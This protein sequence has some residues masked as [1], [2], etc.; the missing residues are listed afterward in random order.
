MMHMLLPSLF[1]ACPAGS[2]R[3]ALGGSRV[4]FINNERVI[5]PNTV[6]HHGDM[7][8]FNGQGDG[9][10]MCCVPDE[11]DNCTHRHRKTNTHTHTHP[12]R[13]A[14]EYRCLIYSF[15]SN[16]DT[17]FEEDAAARWS[18]CEIHIFDCTATVA[19]KQLISDR[20]HT[21]ALCLDVVDEPLL[22]RM[23]FSS[24]L[25]H[26]GHADHDIVVLKMDM[27]GWEWYFFQHLVD[28]VARGRFPRIQQ[29]LFEIHMRI[30]GTHPEVQMGSADFA[31]LMALLLRLGYQMFAAT[32]ND[33]VLEVDCMELSFVQY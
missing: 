33:A 11:P 6:E 17:S 10:K 14:L 13:A 16:D 19:R 18:Q 23:T 31:H 3:E 7:C 29:I 22:R 30:V 12:E 9:A 24:I 32:P 28:L 15:G 26:L 27:E 1:L 2:H 8:Y 20:I 21:H 5:V 4:C 25:Q